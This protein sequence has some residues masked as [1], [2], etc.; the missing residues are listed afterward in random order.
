MAICKTNTEMTQITIE[1]VNIVIDDTVDI[2]E[3]D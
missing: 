2:L 3:T 1:V